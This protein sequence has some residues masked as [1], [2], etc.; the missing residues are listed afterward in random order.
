MNSCTAHLRIAATTDVHMHLTGWDALRDIPLTNEGMDRIATLIRE[1]RRSAK[2]G[3]VLVDNGDALQ[4]TPLGDVCRSTPDAHPWPAVLNALDYDAAGLGNHD[5]D[6]GLSFLERV[7]AQ[8]NCA[9][10]CANAVEGTIKGAVPGVLIERM[11]TCSDCKDRLVRIGLTSVLPPQTA[12]WNRRS[13]DGAVQFKGGVRAA[14]RS[15]ATLRDEGADIVI[16]LCHSGLTDGVDPT[17]ENFGTAIAAEVPGIDALILGHTHLRFPG[18]DHASFDGVDDVAGTLHKIP[19][20][21]PGDAGRE[22]G[23]ID[24]TLAHAEAGWTVAAH[25]VHRREVGVDH[26]PDRAVAR[27]TQPVVE[28]TQAQLNTPMATTYEHLHTWFSMLRPSRAEDLV[29]QAMSS[30]IAQAV[31]GT[32]LAK[33]PVLASVA[34][35]ALGG[36]A[37]PTNFVDIQPGP[38]RERHIAMLTPYPN[39]VWGVVLTGSQIWDWIDRSLAFFAPADAEGDDLINNHAPA[40]NFDAVHGIE[41]DID[42][43][44]PAAFDANGHRMAQCATRVRS[45]AHAGRDVQ[46]QERFL[47]AMT[48]YRGSGGGNFPGIGPETRTVRSDVDMREALRG[49]VGQLSSSKPVT[50]TLPWHFATG[51]DRRCVVRTSPAAEPY[52]AD[53]ADFEP[54]PLG[55]CKDGFLR[56]EVSI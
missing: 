15:V 2:G 53:I 8:A 42:P 37:G 51:G 9:V 17:G 28:A 11:V 30:T 24:L 18:P 34:P 5:F 23:V 27:I 26:A 49:A 46:P 19:T 56:V 6:F 45:L 38:F 54:H 4:G 40:F 21:M 41:A 36:R 33:L 10:L 7:M 44:A 35:A 12:I 29:A 25:D 43:F 1:E 13:L 16:V 3:F 55:I 39:T 14:R 50:T 31:A 47:L 48:S 22:L 32:E 52:L 20:V